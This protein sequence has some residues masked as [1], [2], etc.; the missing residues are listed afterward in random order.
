MLNLVLYRNILLSGLNYKHMI[1]DYCKEGMAVSDFEDIEGFVM[2]HYLN[3]NKISTSSQSVVEVAR[4]LFL[5][6]KIDSLQVQFKGQLIGLKPDGMFETW[7][8]G[9]CDLAEMLAQRLIKLQAKMYK[10][11]GLVK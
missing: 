3:K 5:E 1:I 9:F 6:G 7:P 8:E 4:I 2:S 11:N 10:E